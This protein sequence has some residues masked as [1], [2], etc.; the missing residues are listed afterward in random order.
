M[1]KSTLLRPIVLAASLV[2]F[3]VASASPILPSY[4]T[5]GPLSAANF[6][7]SGIPN[8]SVAIDSVVDGN[9][10]I[11]LGLTAHQRYSNPAVTNDGAGTF[12]AAAGGDIYSGGNSNADYARW[13][14]GLYVDFAPNIGLFTQNP[15][16]LSLYFDKDPALGNSVT[17]SFV[18]PP[19]FLN[20]IGSNDVQVSWNLGMA[21]FFGTGFNPVV[22]GEY[23]FA[24]VLSKNGSELGRSAI[25]VVVGNPQPPAPVPDSGSVA[26]LLGTALT[27]LGLMRRA[28]RN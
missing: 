2:I 23:S 14:L 8:H 21:S 9:R 5:F 24:L 18:L 17:S 1:T 13:N 15:Y 3:G 25:N 22:D 6:G 12:F 28:R 26:L 11:T 20:P 27:T 16:T 4:D 10:T 7:G 19:L